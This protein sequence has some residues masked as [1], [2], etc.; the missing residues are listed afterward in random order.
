MYQNL[1]NPGD[2]IIHMDRP[3][4]IDIWDYIQMRK[5]HLSCV[6]KWVYVRHVVITKQGMTLWELSERYLNDQKTRA[7]GQLESPISLFEWLI[8]ELQS[9]NNS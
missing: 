6:V 2:R 5:Q 7:I 9:K 4:I 3:Q 8:I 1:L